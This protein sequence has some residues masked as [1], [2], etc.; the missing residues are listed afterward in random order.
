MVYLERIM[1]F[2]IS[3]PMSGFIKYQIF[4]ELKPFVFATYDSSQMIWKQTEGPLKTKYEDYIT[5]DY[6]FTSEAS[7]FMIKELF[8][9]G[10]Q[11]I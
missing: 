7:R 9:R 3:F 8:I 6:K 11:V 2:V 10:V 5:D 1:N 4:I